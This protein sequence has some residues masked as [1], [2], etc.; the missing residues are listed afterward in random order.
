MTLHPHEFI[1]RFLI[2]VLPK[3][4]HRIRHYGLFANGNR[5]ANIARLRELLRVA[6]VLHEPQEVASSDDQR[7]LPCS[8]PRCGGRMII[9]ETFE[10]GCQPL[11]R[12]AASQPLAPFDTS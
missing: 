9:I 2:H 8:C 5:A 7:Q 4:F 10:P 6:T 1:R 11:N 3:G 12:P